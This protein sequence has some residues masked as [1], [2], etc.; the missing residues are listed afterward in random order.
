MGHAATQRQGGGWPELQGNDTTLER[1][2]LLE[3]LGCRLAL[4][5]PDIRDGV[6]DW[7]KLEDDTRRDVANFTNHTFVPR[8]SPDP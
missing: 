7:I 5:W 2:K 1:L 8:E 3:R 6:E 4:I